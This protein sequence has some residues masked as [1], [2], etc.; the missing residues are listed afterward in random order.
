MA[1]PL[2]EQREINRRE[3]K[4]RSAMNLPGDIL[5][6]QFMLRQ[7][8]Y[9]ELPS[10]SQQSALEIAGHGLA[11]GAEKLLAPFDL[12]GSS[13]RDV[14]SGAVTGDWK[15]FNPADQLL[16][17]F[18][19]TENRMDGREH[20]RRMGAF[21]MSPKGED[22]WGNFFGGVAYEVATDPVTY[23]PGI[24]LLNV[25]HKLYRAGKSGIA[26]A[27]AANAADSA[28]TAALRVPAQK[29]DKVLDNVET[30]GTAMFDRTA[31]GAIGRE[32]QH[33]G[34]KMFS[35]E[36]QA[37]YDAADMSAEIRKGFIKQGIDIK[38]QDI[39]RDFLNLFEDPALK[40]VKGEVAPFD[41]S[42]A[43]SLQKAEPE[44][45]KMQDYLV[46]VND[47]R[48]SLGLPTLGLQDIPNYFPRQAG[49]VP[50]SV[51]QVLKETW[52][53]S[54]EAAMRLTG[55]SRRMAPDLKSPHDIARKQWL[56]V[57]EG[58]TRLLQEMTSDPDLVGALRRGG[59]MPDMMREMQRKYGGELP[60]D[61]FKTKKQG[62]R[63]HHART[64]AKWIGRMDDSMTQQGGFFNG[65]FVD[66]FT[67]YSRHSERVLAA[68][69]TLLGDIAD[70]LKPGL[71]EMLQRMASGQPVGVPGVGDLANST[72]LGGMFKSLGMNGKKASSNLFKKVTGEDATDDILSSFMKLRVPKQFAADTHRMLQ[73]LISDRKRS[74]WL[75]YFH[76]VTNLFKR[77]V[78]GHFPS[79]HI[80][81]RTSAEVQNIAFGNYGR[82]PAT[83]LPE[84]VAQNANTSKIFKGE[85]ITG[86]A[87]WDV[88]KGAG[89]G[90]REATDLLIKSILDMEIIGSPTSV[91][92]VG[93]D[94]MRVNQLQR[95]LDR[96]LYGGK[97]DA[98]K[99]FTTQAIKNYFTRWGE[100]A[101]DMV[102]AYNRIPA[103]LS[104]IK[105]EGGKFPGSAQEKLTA[106]IREA[107]QQIRL[108]Q[109]DYSD[110]T[111]FE[112]DY[113]KVIFPFYGFAKGIT[114]GVATELYEHPAGG[115]MQS[116][117]LQARGTQ[118]DRESIERGEILPEYMQRGGALPFGRDQEGNLSALTDFGLMHEQVLEAADN[119][120][121]MSLGMLNPLI[122]GTIEGFSGTS[123]YH[124]EPL[125][126]LDPN[127]GRLWSNLKQIT[128][129]V[130]TH[131]PAP[132]AG[133]L[134]PF[135]N[136]MPSPYVVENWISS[137]P[138]TRYLSTLR[139]L[140]DTRKYQPV[141]MF[142][143]PIPPII[144]NILTGLKVSQ[145]SP[146]RQLHAT[147]ELVNNRM[148][149]MGLGRSAKYVYV[150]RLKTIDEREAGLMALQRKL[151]RINPE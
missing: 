8:D 97:V 16:T 25:A 55:K 18:S 53:L 9:D 98:P 41:F 149:E 7:L 59:T 85:A 122:K 60:A 151:Q 78:T 147:R 138:A 68:A 63:R 1:V 50:Q 13:V 54:G 124:N 5:P 134:K 79:F 14:I 150:P 19:L 75:D 140:T 32:G 69:D 76:K 22:T 67:G 87:D 130:K 43:P 4:R 70:R 47:R 105:R 2:S 96:D 27:A 12:M 112:K 29:L 45:R 44:I 57:G 107:S 125:S 62:G 101:G 118:Q 66:A 49:H 132:M 77:S 39:Q 89:I 82:N 28:Y 30:I 92:D 24:G 123:L 93:G 71:E 108:S 141:E 91:G 127:V 137:S 81:N 23:L 111:P 38:N 131:H 46:D 51:R 113:M 6:E 26:K 88:F 21:G 35:A 103:F 84:M 20:L 90:D 139:T 86:A 17:P 120:G 99:V 83:A 110:M 11:T 126:Q 136:V 61:F 102:E 104:I 117:R 80:R 129:G 48:A 36:E 94:F 144:P 58:G 128:T 146:Q 95:V 100:N 42:R 73:P 106:A 10:D 31:K 33:L 40:G 115:L 114:K 142:G 56:K 74:F 109:I 145:V 3:K 64:L 135:E 52:E 121:A 15:E 72:T 148:E 119:A 34:R 37:M 65:D 116:I 133:V 143:M